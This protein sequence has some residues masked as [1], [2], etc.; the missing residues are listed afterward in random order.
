[1]SVDPI[2][3]LWLADP[4][5]KSHHVDE[6]RGEDGK[7]RVFTHLSSLRGP[8]VFLEPSS[9]LVS[10]TNMM[11]QQRIFVANRNSYRANHMYGTCNEH[12]QELNQNHTIGILKR[13]HI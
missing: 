3:N 10:L 12:V 4:V 9:D 1:L 2:R 6:N 13:F 5:S 8:R 7:E 11:V